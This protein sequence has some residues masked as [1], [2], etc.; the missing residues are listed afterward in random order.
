MENLP[1]LIEEIQNAFLSG[2]GKKNRVINKIYKFSKSL[3]SLSIE[4]REIRLLPFF[5]ST[6][7][8]VRYW[9]AIIALS[10]K[11]FE[12]E[13]LKSLLD[14]LDIPVLQLTDETMSLNL[15]KWDIET[16]LYQLYKTGKIG[17][18][19][20]PNGIELSPKNSGL[21]AN[22]NKAIAYFR[23]KIKSV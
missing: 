16:Y 22:T 13:S 2:S 14:I 11:V 1:L 8:Y 9:G 19:P 20:N 15:L 12:N 6:H 4:E 5:Q 17:S 21:L 23:K 3:E 10:H 7:V 18:Y